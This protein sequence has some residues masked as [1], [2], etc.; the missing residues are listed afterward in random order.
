[1]ETEN[2]QISGVSHAADRRVATNLHLHL[3]VD[4]ALRRPGQLVPVSQSD[5]DAA[6]T[7]DRDQTV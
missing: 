4:S 1:M 6:L 3:L 7:K 2:E 5:L